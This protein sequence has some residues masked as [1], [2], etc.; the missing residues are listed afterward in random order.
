MMV[1]MA[2]GTFGEVV[3]VIAVVVVVVV[4]VVGG[5]QISNEDSILLCQ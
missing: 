4:V 5:G 3:V 1:L 2:L